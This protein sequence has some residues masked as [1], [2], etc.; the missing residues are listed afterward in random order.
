MI[1]YGNNGI[2][3]DNIICGPKDMDLEDIRNYCTAE[4]ELEDCTINPHDYVDVTDCMLEFCD[5]KWVHLFI[6]VK[7]AVQQLP[8]RMVIIRQQI[9]F[10]G[11]INGN[12]EGLCDAVDPTMRLKSNQV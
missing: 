1:N 9:I 4:K 6:I 10:C 3:V 8:A 11:P 7:L 2:H 12:F 5:L